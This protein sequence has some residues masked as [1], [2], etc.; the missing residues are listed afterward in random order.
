MKKVM[1]QRG[2]LTRALCERCKHLHNG[3]GENIKMFSL[4][5]MSCHSLGDK[6]VLVHESWALD[7]HHQH[8]HY[9]QFSNIHRTSPSSSLAA[10]DTLSADLANFVYLDSEVKQAV[11]IFGFTGNQLQNCNDD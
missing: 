11:S 1:R 4:V 7:T 5:Q 2:Q 9:A 3:E 6:D 10:A 8:H